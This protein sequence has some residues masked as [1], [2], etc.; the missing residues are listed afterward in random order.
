[1]INF[2]RVDGALQCENVPL[3]SLIK[4]FGTPAYVYSKASIINNLEL[5]MGAF[6]SIDSLVCFSVKSNSNLSILHLMAQKGAGADIVSGGELFCALQAGIDPKVIVFSG[7]GKTAD[8]LRY[9]LKTG[10]RMFNVESEPELMRLSAVA[11]SVGTIAPVALRVN[12]DIDAK[13]HT[14]TTTAK[15]ENKFGLPFK[16]AIAVYKKASCLPF[17]N[18]IGIDVHLGS[19]ILSLEPYKKALD[20][21]SGLV[22]ELRSLNINIHILDIGGGFGIVYN[23][24]KPF[25]PIQFSNL[26]VPYLDS[27]KCSLI[28]EPGRFIVGNSGVLLTTIT[29]VKKT[30]EKVF[31][32]C[33]AGMSDLIRPPLYDAFHE[34]VPVT[35]PLVPA[36]ITADIVGPICE[37]SDFLAKGRKI[38]QLEQNAHLAVKSAG[39]YGFSMASQYNSRPRAC[40]ILVDGSSYCCVRNRE[41]YEDLIRGQAKTW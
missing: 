16:T 20:L 27:M 36:M 8:E 32:I 38:E 35:L 3:A 40:E 34:I 21:L 18:P 11:E 30:D 6:G 9:A 41:T 1:M 14:Y 5:F 23:D 2:H 19:P 37:S 24:E 33:D 13:T 31:Y 4:E 15:K 25:T 29:Y 28:I 10:I 12:P 26:I 17:I 39:A 7:V 22:A